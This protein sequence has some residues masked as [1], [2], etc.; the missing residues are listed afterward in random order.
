MTRAAGGVADERSVLEVLRADADDHLAALAAVG[1]LPDLVGHL[2]R[3]EAAVEVA[4]LD[5]RRQ[6]V[7]RRAADEPGHEQVVRP[8]V[9]LGRRADLLHD[10][11]LHHHDPVAERHRLGLVVGDVER[12][13]RQRLLDARDLGAHLDAQLGVEVRQRLVHQERLGTAHDRA[14]HRHP[15]PLA[16]GEVGRLAVEVHGQ[17]EHLGGLVDLALDG[18]LVDAGKD[19]REGHVLPHRHVR[20][21]R[22]GLEHHRDVTVLG[23]LVVDHLAVDAAA[24]PG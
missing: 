9:E 1:C 12:G 22:V 10:A 16:T 13:R 24:H 7:H 14:T 15:L 11:A 19:E 6:E 17:L 21:E 20:V 4:A 23:R 3:A 8:L 18:V 5:G 2:E